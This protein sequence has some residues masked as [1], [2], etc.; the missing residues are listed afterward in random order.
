MKRSSP[1]KRIGNSDLGA[2][3]IWDSF[4]LIILVK[5]YGANKRKREMEKGL[6]NHYSHSP[7]MLGTCPY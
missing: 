1:F 7:A 4:F 6:D 2:Q 5:D 3:R